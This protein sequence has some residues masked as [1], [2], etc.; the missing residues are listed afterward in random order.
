MSNIQ[1]TSVWLSEQ[2]EPDELTRLGEIEGGYT[3][4]EK[5]RVILS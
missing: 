5:Y 3:F 1:N 4:E 2:E